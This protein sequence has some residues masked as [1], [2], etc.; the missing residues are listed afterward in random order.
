[1]IDMPQN[2]FEKHSVTTSKLTYTP[3]KVCTVCWLWEGYGG[4]ER[5]DSESTASDRVSREHWNRPNEFMLKCQ[6]PNRIPNEIWP[7]ILDVA[8]VT[9]FVVSAIFHSK[10]NYAINY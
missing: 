9:V 4:G 5:V 8:H 1:M 10:L 7:L 6:F 3:V 2:G